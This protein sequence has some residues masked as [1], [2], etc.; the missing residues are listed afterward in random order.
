[1]CAAGTYTSLMFPVRLDI[2]L[3]EVF[4]GL[5]VVM[6]IL[7]HIF[8]LSIVHLMLLIIIVVTSV[9]PSAALVLY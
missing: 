7:L 5:R 2:Q 4:I 6:L 1:M 9:S 8:L 3:L